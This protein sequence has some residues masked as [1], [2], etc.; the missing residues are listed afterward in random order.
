MALA[1]GKLTESERRVLLKRAEKEGVDREEFEIVLEARLFEAEKQSKSRINN[2]ISSAGS[3]KYG[4]M[5]KCPG[6]GAIVPAFAGKCHV[7][8]T[9]FHNVAANK[10]TKNLFK[11]LDL[12]EQK[13]EKEN[14]QKKQK[15]GLNDNWYD[16]WIAKENKAEVLARKQKSI[17][18]AFPV[19]NSKADLLEIL[20]VFRP[21]II[22]GANSLMEAFFI[23]Y[24]EC[25]ERSKV[26]FPGDSMFMP[27]IADFKLLS[28]QYR[29]RNRIYKIKAF[30]KKHKVAI[31]FILILVGD[32]LLLSIFA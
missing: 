13:N 3:T 20:T 11:E 17:I 15:E 23:K 24:S 16:N 1:D 26:L 28:N 5:Y 29:K 14:E 4:E 32:V 30:C 7:C 27:I 8:G 19:P 10:F 6:C 21:Q 22:Y 9:E 2:H 18:M 25:L 31:L 12:I